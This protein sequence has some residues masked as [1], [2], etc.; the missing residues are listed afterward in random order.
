MKFSNTAL[1]VIMGSSFILKLRGSTVFLAAKRFVRT[2]TVS[3]LILALHAAS[4]EKPKLS[5]RNKSKDNPKRQSKESR[6]V[7]NAVSL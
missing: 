4:I 3:R 5:K 6:S 2:A 7:P 1:L